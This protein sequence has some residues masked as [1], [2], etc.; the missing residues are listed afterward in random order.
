MLSLGPNQMPPAVNQPFTSFPSDFT[1]LPTV[2]IVVPNVQDDMHD[3]TVQQADAW[4]K[5][6][7]DTYAQWAKANNSLLIVTWDEDDET[8]PSSNPANHIPTIFFGQMVQPGSYSEPINDYNILRTVEDM[9]N[10]PH[11]GASATATPIT[12]IWTTPDSVPRPDHVV[13]VIEENH[14]YSEI[15]GSAGA[16]YVNS[17]VQQGVLMTDSTAITHPS[18]P[19]YLALFSG[20]VQ[21]ITDDNRPADLPFS[22]PNLGAELLAAGDTFV[23]YAESLPTAGFDGDSYTTVAGQNQYVRRHNPWSDF[24][25]THSEQYVMAVYHD[26]LG[27]APDASGL[28][29]WSS[30]LDQGVAVSSVAAAIAHSVEYYANFVIKPAYQN[31]LGRAADASGVTYWTQKMQTGLTDQQLEAG[32]VASDE[33]YA[34]AGGNNKAWIDQLYLKLLGRAADSKGETYWVGQLSSGVSRGEVAQLIANSAENDSQ[35]ITTDYEHYLGRTPDSMGLSFW[36]QQFSDGQ[37]NEDL[38]A[39]FTG[40][41]EYYDEHTT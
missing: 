17:L 35:L 29:Y 41:A 21:G 26:V 24:M 5:N 11:A 2:S 33:F 38:I 36:L 19:N 4:L 13:M 22:T 1:K 15:V 28:T 25:A 27:R 18:Q 23:G 3:G 40:S 31:L 10:L 30:Q 39:G 34:N 37:T 9:Y 7:L 14:N 6:N 8:N 20:S 32:F 12:D 16:P